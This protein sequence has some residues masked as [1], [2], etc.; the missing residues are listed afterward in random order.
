MTAHLDALLPKLEGT[1][2]HG[3]ASDLAK[4]FHEGAQGP[5]RLLMSSLLFTP[6]W[7]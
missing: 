3:F 6:T 5:T 4:G 7:G 2:V 1:K